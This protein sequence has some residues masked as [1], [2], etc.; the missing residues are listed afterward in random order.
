MLH[1]LLDSSQVKIQVA[2][3]I[4]NMTLEV[5]KRNMNR[6]TQFNGFEHFSYFA[7][8]YRALFGE[9]PSETLRRRKG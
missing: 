1:L 2:G 9:Y 5:H 6:L 3:I 8:D 7:R 4:S